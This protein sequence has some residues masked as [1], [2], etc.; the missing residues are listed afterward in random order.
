M[1]LFDQGQVW[2]RIEK[3][4]LARMMNYTFCS[5]AQYTEQITSKN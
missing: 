3:L 5:T 1:K 2:G 4:G